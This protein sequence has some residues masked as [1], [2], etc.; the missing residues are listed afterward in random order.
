MRS[1]R[2]ALYAALALTIFSPGCNNEKAAPP[3]AC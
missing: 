2:M 1:R 3:K